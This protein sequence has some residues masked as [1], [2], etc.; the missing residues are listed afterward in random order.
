MILSMIASFHT[1]EAGF[2]HAASPPVDMDVAAA[3]DAL[4]SWRQHN[5]EAS[6]SPI[7]DR[8]QNRPI[9]IVPLDPGSLFGARSRKPETGVWMRLRDPADTDPL[10][11]R[12]LL[13]Y[14]SD[15]MFLR[16]AMLPH[17][18]RPGSSMVQAASLDHAIWFHETPDFNQWHLFATDSPW[19]GHARGLNHGHFFDENGRMV[20][21]VSQESL[22]RPK[23][24]VL[25]KLRESET[26]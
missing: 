1:P 22:M 13:A 11:Q 18:V 5:S 10:L 3:L 19:A 20:A 14:A 21:T 12:A 16:N 9:E 24:E 8:L 23:G 25:D 6:Q 15:M 26:R 7:I 17:A 4:E 2:A